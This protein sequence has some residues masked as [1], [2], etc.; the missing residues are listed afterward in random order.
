[1]LEEGTDNSKVSP[2]HCLMYWSRLVTILG[3]SHLCCVRE[4]SEPCSGVSGWT[5]PTDKEMYGRYLRLRAF[6]VHYTREGPGKLQAV[7]LP[8]HSVAESPYDYPLHSHLRC[9]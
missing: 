8:R 1:M 7:H 4:G 2:F 9:T 6:D 5:S 3:I